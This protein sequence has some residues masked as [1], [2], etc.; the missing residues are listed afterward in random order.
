MSEGEVCGVQARR[1][2]DTVTF[3]TL[4]A[5]VTHVSKHVL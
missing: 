1:K 4:T 3:L 2:E 5:I